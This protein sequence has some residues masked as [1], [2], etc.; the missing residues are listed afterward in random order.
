VR[1]LA[2][3]VGL[4]VGEVGEVTMAIVVGGGVGGGGGGVCRVRFR[5]VRRVVSGEGV[6]ELS[7]FVPSTGSAGESLGCCWEV[8]LDFGVVF[9]VCRS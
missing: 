9:P 6:A 3:A 5:F 2:V 7:Q 4:G 1:A 8:T